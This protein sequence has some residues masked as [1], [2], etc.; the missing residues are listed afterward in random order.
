ME[1]GIDGHALA[2]YCQ[3]WARW[4]KAELFVRKHGDVYLLKDESN[5]LKRLM[6]FPQVAIADKLA[7]QLT[8]LEQEFGM[9]PSAPTR[10]NMPVA[11]LVCD[12]EKARFFQ[13]SG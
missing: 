8:R 2:R 12:P 1:A 4:K 6:Q 5:R 3:L 11:T 10:I 7:A 9:T 13:R